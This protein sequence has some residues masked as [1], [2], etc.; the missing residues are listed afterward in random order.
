[1]ETE[2]DNIAHQLEDA[3]N[4]LRKY[5]DIA[6]IQ[7]IKTIEDAKHIISQA[8]L[9]VDRDL[10][11]VKAESLKAFEEVEKRVW[12]ATEIDTDSTNDMHVIHKKSFERL[13]NVN[14]LINKIIEDAKKVVI[15]SNHQEGQL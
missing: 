3:S 14:L 15:I 13:L 11:H 5:F 6:K 1:M 10:D 8:V 2:K 9:Q 12:T 4:Q 7:F